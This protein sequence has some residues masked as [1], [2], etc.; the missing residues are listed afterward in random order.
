M[1]LKGCVASETQGLHGRS[2]LFGDHVRSSRRNGC[3]CALGT[4]RSGHMV[5]GR[6]AMAVVSIIIR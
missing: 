5:E 1:R 2:H 6:A 4:M 3:G